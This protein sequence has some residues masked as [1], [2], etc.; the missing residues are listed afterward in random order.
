V[1]ATHRQCRHPLKNFIFALANPR[2]NPRL[3]AI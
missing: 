3:C 2:A 1:G